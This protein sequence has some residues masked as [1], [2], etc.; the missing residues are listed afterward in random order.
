M[1]L[2][3]LK[4]SIKP[5]FDAVSSDI[6]SNRLAGLEVDDVVSALARLMESDTPD[7]DL[8]AEDVKPLLEFFAKRWERIRNTN[9]EYTSVPHAA[10]SQACF[11]VATFLAPIVKTTPQQILMPTI[12]YT[13]DTLGNKLENL[14]LHEFVLSDD[15]ICFI[16]VFDCLSLACEDGELRL[17][18]L[19]N[20]KSRLLSESEK[21]RVI[22]HSKESKAFYEAIQNRK[23]FKYESETFGA[24][25]KRLMKDLREAGA[26]KNGKKFEENAGR[27]AVE[28]VRVF[29]EWRKILTPEEQYFLGNLT[30]PNLNENHWRYQESNETTV[31]DDCKNIKEMLDR[32]VLVDHEQEVRELWEMKL[33]KTLMAV[34]TQAEL[35][36]FN[37]GAEMF[38][39]QADM[40]MLSLRKENPER[41]QEI[42]KVITRNNEEEERVILGF[43]RNIYCGD[44]LADKIER[45]LSANPDLYNMIPT[46]MDDKDGKAF[47]AEFDTDF[48][49][50]KS[51]LD[52]AMKSSVYQVNTLYPDGAYFSLWRHFPNSVSQFVRILPEF[53]KFFKYLNANNV[54]THDYQCIIDQLKPTLLTIIDPKVVDFPSLLDLMDRS[55][56]MVLIKALGDD[57]QKFVSKRS[58]LVSIICCI[59]N[60]ADRIFVLDQFTKQLFQLIQAPKDLAE[61]MGA[62]NLSVVRDIKSSKELKKEITEFDQ[63]YKALMNP[64]LYK[65]LMLA[66]TNVYSQVCHGGFFGRSKQQ[67]ADAAYALIRFHHGEISQKEY[68]QHELKTQKG[69][70]SMLKSCLG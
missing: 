6:H 62:L 35:K 45:I 9:L 5:L 40:I 18:V 29:N 67:K 13:E 32:L 10:L 2:K 33:P 30:A 28:A 66:A 68:Q 20:G 39:D 23:K 43:K 51:K 14:K 27:E 26:K 54:N 56:R 36:H 53:A 41:Y 70:L 3:L 22:N 57:L 31:A 1:S 49:E 17:T 61:L 48:N 69:V 60:I 25:L 46:N 37:V 24:A 11:A 19:I 52:T 65:E 59:P 4:D 64:A 8:M 58:D 34:L 44:T 21:T 12:E 55:A 15:K 16:P 47:L 50:A 7:K 63:R 42:R 38:K